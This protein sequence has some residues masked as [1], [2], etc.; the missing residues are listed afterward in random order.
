VIDRTG[1]APC[2]HEVGLGAD[3]EE[4]AVAVE[5]VQAAEIEEPSVHDV[6]CTGLRQQVIEDPDLVHLAAA[7]EDE[8]RDISAQ[9][10]QRVQL[11]SG[12][13]GAERRPREHGQAQIDGG[14]VQGVDRFLQVDAERF[15]QIEPLAMCIS[16]SAK[17]A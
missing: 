12:P 17:S 16:L 8:S 10:E 6:E 4:A 2:G 5:A 1:V 14:G 3:H 13:G 11:D 9:I 15:V 7:D